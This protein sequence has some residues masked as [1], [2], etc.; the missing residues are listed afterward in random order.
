MAVCRQSAASS[1][2]R[3]ARGG[4]DA[5]PPGAAQSVAAELGAAAREARRPGG[6]R[7]DRQGQLAQSER[8]AQILQQPHGLASPAAFAAN[9]PAPRRLPQS[10]VW[11]SQ[12]PPSCGAR[13]QSREDHP[14]RARTFPRTADER[15]VRGVPTSLRRGRVGA[16][17]DEHQGSAR[18]S[19]VRHLAADVLLTDVILR[20]RRGKCRT[21]RVRP[22]YTPGSGLLSARHAIEHRA[23]FDLL[24][25]A[26]IH[27]G[28]LDPKKKLAVLLQLASSIEL[29][30]QA[31]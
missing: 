10:P 11:L 1:G 27:C 14:L 20:P 2:I 28:L 22:C 24:P 25:R 26:W 4:G 18:S 30:R 21:L 8:S 7:L 5:E 16:E 23:G 19:E 9:A 3:S 6:A 17:G 13:A 12:V 29:P 31:R 15:Y